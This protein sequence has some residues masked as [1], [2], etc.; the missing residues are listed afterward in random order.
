MLCIGVRNTVVWMREVWRGFV[1]WTVLLGERDTVPTPCAQP[2]A[3]STVP[4]GLFPF[5]AV[6]SSPQTSSYLLLCPA[7]PTGDVCSSPSS[8]PIQQQLSNRAIIFISNWMISLSSLLIFFK[9]VSVKSA[10]QKKEKQ[11]NRSTLSRSARTVIFSRVSRGS[12]P[13]EV[14][15]G[16]P[17]NPRGGHR[18]LAGQRV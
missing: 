5:V 11:M 1:I 17:L 3:S 2:W 9:E 7:H 10:L 14:L 4:L 16:D 8:C 15:G 13:Q 12:E 18:L 6:L